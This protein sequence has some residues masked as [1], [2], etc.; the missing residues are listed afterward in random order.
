MALQNSTHYRHQD[1]LWLLSKNLG[2][3]F[4]MREVAALRAHIDS[5]FRAK[6]S[7]EVIVRKFYTLDLK[8]F[9]LLET[10]EDKERFLKIMEDAARNIRFVKL[11]FSGS[12]ADEVDV[13]SRDLESGCLTDI[14]SMDGIRGLHYIAADPENKLNLV[15]GILRSVGDYVV[16][17]PAIFGMASWIIDMARNVQTEDDRIGGR[18]RGFHPYNQD[19]YT[20]YHYDEDDCDTLIFPGTFT[21]QIRSF[22]A[23]N[24]REIWGIW[25]SDSDFDKLANLI[26]AVVL[27][28]VDKRAEAVYGDG[29]GMFT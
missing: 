23:Y 26:R 24:F 2:S 6:E 20:Q 5:P 11:P 25:L 21:E 7:P 1:Y 12:L 10:A 19:Q 14:K 13:M 27:E 28:E 4:S 3:Y 18:D 16:G 17:C 22:L 9:E 8:R 15:Y 29:K